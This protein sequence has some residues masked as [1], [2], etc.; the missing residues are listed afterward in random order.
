M[1]LRFYGLR[2]EPFS[3]APDPHFL[4][5]S[6]RHREALAHLRYGLAGSGGFVVLTGEI[7]AG[8]TTVCRCLLE[9]VP[10]Q[11]NV[12][13]LFNPKLTV[14]ELLRTVCADFGIVSPREDER[15]ASLKDYIDALNA[16][17]LARHAAGEHN[18]LIVDEAQALP[19]DLLEQ[20]RLL[21][22]LETHERKLLQIVLIGQPELR[23]MLARPELEQLAQRVVARFHL[24]TLDETETAQY[25]RHRLT[26]A[27][28]EG[29]MP[30]DAGAIKRIHALARGVP[31]RIN[32]LADRAL[33]GGYAEGRQPVDRAI[34]DKAAREV[35]GEGD[36]A[37]RPAAS[38]GIDWRWAAVGGVLAGVVV[39]GALAAWWRGGGPA[40]EAAARGP[41][42]ARVAA[43]SAGVPDAA[44]SVALAASAATVAAAS[45]SAVVAQLADAPSLATWVA[46]EASTDEAQAWQAL[47]AH[48]RV[49]TRDSAPCST[50]PAENLHC[51][52]RRGALDATLA[53]DRPAIL[54]LYD[55]EGVARYVVLTGVS[56]GR[57][58]LRAGDQE[59]WVARSLLATLWREESG[60][61]W[62]PPPGTRIDRQGLWL[63]TDTAWLDAQLARALPA[64]APPT[65]AASRQQALRRFQAQ[66]GLPAD[67]LAGPMTVMLL[68]SDADPTLPS[69]RVKD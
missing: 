51:F 54:P 19:A 27:G 68:A 42:P 43:S 62:R 41:A 65:D 4:Y 36:A 32:L 31:R 33:L 28:L 48:W 29:A 66:A 22:N 59:A 9:Q 52:K 20:L 38:A 26:V 53:L 47:A 14:R 23:E 39:A 49:T 21:T 5:L 1:Y 7:G 3:I 24:G 34:V 55:R 46:A 17:L 67:G 8:K 2:Q 60:T 11:C 69:L 61:L 10:A 63:G 57:V 25:L 15:T 37:R 18:V 35:F 12:A 13:Y 45:A 30:F 44:A 40:G 56:Q 6:P 58:R 50:L 64:L 16:F